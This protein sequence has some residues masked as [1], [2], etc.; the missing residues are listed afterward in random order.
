[1]ETVL[2]TVCNSSGQFLGDLE[3]PVRVPFRRL[4]GNIAEALNGYDASLSLRTDR[5]RLFS[6]RLNRFLDGR[7][8]LESSGLLNGDYLEINVG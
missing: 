3:L 1:M 7:E 6:P 4:A 5:C 8:T 2:L